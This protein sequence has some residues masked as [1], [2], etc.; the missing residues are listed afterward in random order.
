VL[1]GKSISFGDNLLCSALLTI[2]SDLS[3]AFPQGEFVDSFRQDWLTAMA[4]EI[5][6]NRE[7]QDRTTDTARWAREQIKRQTGEHHPRFNPQMFSQFRLNVRDTS[8]LA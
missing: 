7:F 2:S 6:A 4:R 5:R 8:M 1:L 3:R